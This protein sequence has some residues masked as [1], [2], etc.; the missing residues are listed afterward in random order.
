MLLTMLTMLTKGQESL[1]VV[2]NILVPISGTCP[3]VRTQI[4][5]YNFA[6]LSRNLRFPYRG[7]LLSRVASRLLSVNAYVN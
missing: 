4:R 6:A 5:Q 7:P 2:C 1:V 3:Y